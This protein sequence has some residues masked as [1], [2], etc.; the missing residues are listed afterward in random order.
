MSMIIVITITVIHALCLV[1]KQKYPTAGHAAS[2]SQSI[3]YIKV[4]ISLPAVS[5]YRLPDDS[6]VL[7]SMPLSIPSSSEPSV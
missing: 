7:S 2:I 1:L 4:S 6:A 3:V 5:A